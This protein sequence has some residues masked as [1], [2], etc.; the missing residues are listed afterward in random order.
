MRG[1]FGNGCMGSSSRSS[2]EV[3]VW[4][5]IADDGALPVLQKVS[6]G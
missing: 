5:D 4:E 1:C 2:L 3:P 6:P